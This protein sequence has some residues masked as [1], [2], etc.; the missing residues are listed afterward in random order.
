[1][2]RHTTRHEPKASLLDAVLGLTSL[3]TLDVSLP[4]NFEDPFFHSAKLNVIK[5]GWP[6]FAANLTTLYLDVPLEEIHLILL[7]H[8][9]L[10]QLEKFS[11]VLHTFHATSESYELIRTSLLPF[12]ID[13][14]PTL[15]SLKLFALEDLNMSSMLTSLQHMPYLSDLDIAHFF[16]GSELTSFIGHHQFLEAHGSHLQHLTLEFMEQPSLF[17]IDMSEFFNQEWCRVLLPELQTLSFGLSPRFEVPHETAIPYFQRHIPTVKS[18][19]IRSLNFSHDQFSSILT[20]P[21]P[22]EYRLTGLG[23]LDIQILCFSPA[24]LSLLVDKTPHLRLLRLK[25]SIIGPDKQPEPWGRNR[26]PEVSRL[27]FSSL[28]LPGK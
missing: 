25:A 4:Y 23:T 7:S 3:T 13:H 27:S 15:R 20:G 2:R 14:G 22:G 24:F 16:L 8:I 12:L 17:D 26:V 28:Y 11:I 1:M 18:L 6:V 10:L 5:A 21:K 9:V 19:T